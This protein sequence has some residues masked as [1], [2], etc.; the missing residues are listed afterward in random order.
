MR[1]LPF[2]QLTALVDEKSSDIELTAKQ[3]RLRS[4]MATTI[5]GLLSEGFYDKV[6]RAL[7]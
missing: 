7:R 1:D 4:R 6:H 3:R 2:M 5:G